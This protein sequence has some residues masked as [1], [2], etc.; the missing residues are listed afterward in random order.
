MRC[1]I[2]RRHIVVHAEV[3]LAGIPYGF[4]QLSVPLLANVVVLSAF[5]TQRDLQGFRSRIVIIGA[6]P[7]EHD[8]VRTVLMNQKCPFERP[9]EGNG[10]GVAVRRR[11]S[12]P[13]LR[14]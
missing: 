14:R 13:I 7:I 11:L 4:L 1:S 6:F 5:A 2:L 9:Q 3:G 10:I 8:S 12:V